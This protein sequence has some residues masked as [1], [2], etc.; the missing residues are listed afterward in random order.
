MPPSRVTLTARDNEYR[1][2]KEF[3]TAARRLLT[4]LAIWA[5]LTGGTVIK[6]SSD[7]GNLG[8]GGDPPVAADAFYTV[9][10][11]GTVTGFM[12]ATD[13]NGRPLT[14]SIVAGPGQGSLQGVNLTTGQFTYAPRTIGVDSFSFRASNGLQVSNAAVVT[15]QI[16]ETPTSIAADKPS[17]ALQ[18]ADDPMMPGAVLVLWDDGHGTLQ[19]VYRGQAVPAQTLATGVMIFAVN[20][21]KPGTIMAS[22]HGGKVLASTDGGYRWHEGAVFSTPCVSGEPGREDEPPMPRRCPMLPEIMS[23][24][25]AAIS[26]ADDPLRTGTWR[27]AISDSRT[28]VMLTRDD[29]N[30]WNVLREL[31]VG[32]IR[33]ATCEEGILCFLDGSGTHFW[34]FPSDP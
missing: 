24:A 33:L 8:P 20:A 23:E 13:P 10:V 11:T 32:D 25:G 28:V 9:A 26:L 17:G 1:I 18:V 21:V 15:V 16:F 22:V 2:M 6:C 31:E 3:P 4:V 29:G 34:R 19:R 12:K 5:I 7:P 27:L 30:T 14:Y